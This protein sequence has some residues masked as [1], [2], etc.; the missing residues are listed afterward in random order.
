MLNSSD[1]KYK[2][3][4]VRFRFILL[5]LFLGVGMFGNAQDDSLQARL[6]NATNEE[7]VEIY[8][9]LFD[10]VQQKS[11][12]A[13]RPYAEKALELTQGINHGE[14]TFRATSALGKYHLVAGQYDVAFG[15]YMNALELADSL[16]NDPLRSKAYNNIGNVHYLRKEA[17]SAMEAYEKAAAINETIQDKD[18]LCTSY[19]NMGAVHGDLGDTATELQYYARAHALAKEI[20]DQLAEAMVLNNIAN[21]YA[22]ASQFETALI[23]LFESL[24]LK[25]EVNNE[26]EQSTTL[27]NIGMMYLNLSQFAKARPYFQRGY[28]LGVK[29]GS[30]IAEDD[31]LHGMS[32]SYYFAGEHEQALDYYIRHVELMEQIFKENEQMKIAALEITYETEAKENENI[33]LKQ[34][35]DLKDLTIAR[36]RYLLYGSILVIVLLVIAGLVVRSRN[37]IKRRL[38]DTEVRNRMTELELIALRAQMDPHFIFNCIGS[39]RNC[40][41]KGETEVADEYLSKF[42]KLLRAILQ[43]STKTNVSLEDELK[44]L[45]YY[46]ELESL[47]FDHEFTY[48]IDS[49]NVDTS[50]IEV[51]VLLVQPF[52][53]NAIKHGLRSKKGAKSIAVEVKDKD[54]S[55]EI[56]IEDNGIGREKAAAIR[57]ASHPGHISVGMS[58]TEER[59]EMTNTSAGHK[60]TITIEDLMDDTGPAGTR[61]SISLPIN[62]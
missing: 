18:Q 47:R 15:H 31:N 11:N 13:A 7:K 58:I 44:G 46:L 30:I 50:G 36:N 4:I 35:A 37:K 28:E 42:A 2:A 56:V 52:V 8:L 45:E 40:L 49:E 39:I 1:L 19:L 12:V 9:D 16:G 54:D 57:R 22:K 26:M 21:V 43:N 32:M 25:E 38:A 23:Y 34:E 6:L 24:S 10:E 3:I 62:D 55:I 33:R 17:E 14:L 51:P 59:L 27:F 48:T 53:E 20:N 5:L 29:A 41:D 61:V 60:P